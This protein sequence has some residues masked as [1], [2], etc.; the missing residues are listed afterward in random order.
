M[1]IVCI[2]DTHGRHTK[3]K[4]L[5]EGDVLVSAGDFTTTGYSKT[6]IRKFTNWMAKQPYEHKIMIA[7]N[8]ERL[9]EEDP[10]RALQQI[11]NE[12]IYLQDSSAVI[13][14]VRFYGS[15]WQPRFFD[16]A[17]NLSRGEQIRKKWEAIP[18]NTDVLITHGPPRDILDKAPNRLIGGLDSC[19]CDDLRD[20]IMNKLS[21]KAHIFGHIHKSYGR[22]IED[23]I[24]FVNAAICNEEYK[25]LN[26]PI[27]IEI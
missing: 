25:P 18:E 5:P 22:Y 3:I 8:H 7:G 21:I 2:S 10:K 20:I 15:P 24:Q 13:D 14:G 17:F 19:G 6:E 27:V 23:D 16:W 4:D 9:F 26:K 1:K 11:N 12:V